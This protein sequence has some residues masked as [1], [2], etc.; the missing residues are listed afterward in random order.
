MGE[1]FTV[2]KKIGE[3]TQNNQNEI[4][5]SVVQ[6]VSDTFK[7][8]EVTKPK[9]P[10]DINAAFKA[11]PLASASAKQ[12]AIDNGVYADGIPLIEKTMLGKINEK[13]KQGKAL[14][15]YERSL[16]TKYGTAGLD[17]NATSDFMEF[18]TKNSKG[19][20]IY[21]ETAIKLLEKQKQGTALT[22]DEH[23]MLETAKTVSEMRRAVLQNTFRLSNDPKQNAHTAVLG[24][25]TDIYNKAAY[26][27]ENER[28]SN[29]EKH[30]ARAKLYLDTGIESF[31]S[32]YATIIN[33]VSGISSKEISE[34]PE[35]ANA[36]ASGA[37]REYY[38]NNRQKLNSVVQDVATNMAQNAIPMLM[39]AAVGAAGGASGSVLGMS[40]ETASRVVST[41]SF[42]PSVFGNAYKEATKTGVTNEGKLLAYAA[43]VTIAECGLES[44]LGS[45]INPA[46]GVLSGEVIEQLSKKVGNVALKAVTK[47]AGNGIGEFTEETIQ[48]L[49]SPILQKY[50]LNVETET[51]FDD[52]ISSLSSAAYEGFIGF[53]SSVLMGGVNSVRSGVMEKAVQQ[54]GAYYKNLLNRLDVDINNIAQYFKEISESKDL[55]KSAE[56]VL[57]GDTSDM[58]IGEMLSHAAV[59]NAESLKMVYVAIG[60]RV[61]EDKNGI[62]LL[63]SSY[64]TTVAT[65]AIYPENVNTLYEKVKANND[66]GIIETAVIGEFA[67]AAQTYAPRA[68]II[69]KLVS[70]TFGTETETKLTQSET[71]TDSNVNATDGNVGDSVFTEHSA[72]KPK[73]DMIADGINYGTDRVRF[74]DGQLKIKALGEKLGRKVKFENTKQTQGFKSDGYIEAD[75]T[76]HIDYNAEKPVEFIFK[77]EITHF[78]ENTDEYR[79]FAEE[80]KGSKAYEQWINKK[81]GGVETTPV[82]SAEYRER[83]MNN[84]KA[85]GITLTPSQAEAELIADFTGEVLFK[86]DGSGLKSIMS[87]MSNTRRG[88]FANFFKSFITYLKGKFTHNK[89]MTAEVLKL[90]YLFNKALTAAE[91]NNNTATEGDVKYSFPDGK[92]TMNMTD[93]ERAELL[94]NTVIKLAEYDGKSDDLNGKNVLLLK[95]SY[96]S[97]AGKILKSLG[98]KFGVF[99]TYNNKN[100]SLDFDYSRGSL[101]ESVHKQGDISTN[102]YD[103]AKM[104][105]VFDEVVKNAVPIEVHTDKYKGTSRENTNLKSDYV[106]LSAFRDKD[107]IVPVEFHLKEMNADSGQE[108]K[109]YVSITLGKIKMEDKVKVAVSDENHQTK[110]TNL[111]PTI[112]IPD[113]ISK[114]NPEYGSFYKYLPE[115]MLNEQQNSSRN[116]AVSDENYRLQVMH[117]ED[118]TDILAETAREKGY[119]KDDNWKMDHKAPNSQDGYSNSMD[120]IDKSYNSDGSIYSQQAVYYYGEGRKYDNKAIS[121]IKSAKNNP[122]KAIKIYRAVPNSIKDTRVR[123]GDWVA[124]VKEYAIEHG[125]RVLDDDFRIIENTVPAKYLFSNGDSINEWGYDN[126]NANEIY[127]NSE[128]NVK[129][130]EVTYDDNGKIIPLSKR[131]NDKN[132]DI[133]FSIPDR[134]TEL[135]EKY[136]NGEISREEYLEESNKNWEEAVKTYGTI[137]EGENAKEKI[138]VPKAVRDDGKT[139]RFVRTVIES[140][141]LPKRM[142]EDMGSELLTGGFEYTPVS[143]K[144]A[145]DEADQAIEN[146]SADEVWS[147]ARDASK[148]VTKEAIATGERL[149]QE[150]IKAKDGRRVLELTAELSDVLT[151]NGQ[152]V[153]AARLF[154]QTTGA[155]RLLSVQRFINKLNA[156]RIERHGNDVPKIALDG[157]IAEQIAASVPGEDVSDIYDE[158][159]RDIAS[160]TGSTVMEK[161]NA[162]RYMSML[163]NP[164]THIRNIIGNTV[165]TPVVRMKDFTAAVLEKAFVDEN[166]RTKALKVEK[167]YKDF[168][169]KYNA[170]SDVRHYL[171][172]N[173]KYNELPQWAQYRRIFQ[174]ELLENIS[175]KNSD[176]LELEDMVFKNIHYRHALAGFLQARK[177]DLNNLSENLLNEANEYAANEA[178]KA[179]FNDSNAVASFLNDLANRHIATDILVN[180]IMPFKKTPINIV[181]RGVE[182][183]PMGL[184][185]EISKGT[186]DLMKKDGKKGKITATEY[187]DGMGAGVSGTA[188]FAL[189][190]LLA[191]L[192]IVTG[193][194]GSDEEDKFRKL[195][196]EQEYALQIGGKSYTIDWAAPACIP[197]FVGVELMN[198]MREEKEDFSVSDISDVMWNSFEPILELSVMSGLQDILTSV[199]YSEEDREVSTIAGEIISSYFTQAL[200]TVGGKTA[201]IIDSKRRNS[202]Y[203]DK[204]SKVSSFSQGILNTAKSKIPG[205]EMTN[206]E[207]VDAWG[208]TESNGNLL[209][210]IFGNFFSPGYASSVDYDE[211]ANEL[212]RLHRTETVQNDDDLHVLPKTATKSF[213]VNGETKYLTADEYEKFAKAKG[214]YSYDYVS[215]FLNGSA[216]KKLTDEERAAV[217]TKLYGYATA[218]AKSE[219]SDY[220]VSEVSAYKNAYKWEKSGKDVVTYYI[221]KVIEKEK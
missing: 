31:L 170:R 114:I 105:Y 17:M 18:A 2:I 40:A 190:M 149:L 24:A 154:K 219:V 186:Y 82:K 131:F 135:R 73:F 203:V 4:R 122:E 38:I 30:T 48:G 86:E 27:T 124:I 198:A 63:L 187:I 181:R 108:N 97:Q 12:Q 67:L 119:S 98:E 214:Q 206:A 179:T 28:T 207:A 95:S 127:K 39:S 216:Y 55:T 59:F 128:N 160:Q 157:R 23:E 182:Y 167:K 118:V 152:T 88:K 50:I 183:S 143:D 153:Q 165:F 33:R 41:A 92:I 89:S 121:I 212:L 141:A 142:L 72:Q 175:K 217:I 163:A 112:S 9:I 173:G 202:H 45:S 76:I 169:K 195:N 109:L 46:G 174:S 26:G 62:D 189:G 66:D 60:Q 164:T 7:Q 148:F 51:V 201:R 146:G 14:T 107:Y 6:P 120:N 81:V 49:L 34:A 218:K 69:G 115:S 125:G 172:S 78:A 166:Q 144:T 58:A 113:L 130:L 110:D 13:V 99:K 3:E 53:L 161:W 138:P 79:N 21:N 220:D 16:L 77:H 22:A 83:I 140:G 100:V 35:N 129:T 200:P 43:T 134:Q 61:L 155:G 151:R 90:E 103:F 159:L 177:A 215:K 37:L 150:A 210:R 133:R 85:N 111:S 74:S 136:D 158:A 168:A 104:L 145:L 44:L 47:I 185:R 20:K 147:R 116:T 56:K 8:S 101:N 87:D 193:G 70:E 68:N 94:N 139:Q 132:P 123:N 171:S 162:L 25:A 96:N 54:N 84:Y 65:G 188:V 10:A 19:N 71:A 102:F 126:G 192:G 184:L 191:S 137:K 208:R 32:G 106:L 180:G 156:D 36:I 93:D 29:V 209:Q 196:G 221:G 80:V 15:A 199:K 42:A 52:P 5:F 213:A 64:E 178:F 57:N 211:T 204:N 205:L 91:Q 75:G 194:F 117:G 197:F 1:R 176:L 11:G